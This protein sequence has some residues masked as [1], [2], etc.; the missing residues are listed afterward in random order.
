LQFHS[1]FPFEEVEHQVS[2]PFRIVSVRPLFRPDTRCGMTLLN[3]LNVAG[4]RKET[5][6]FKCVAFSSIPGRL[7]RKAPPLLGFWTVDVP[8]KGRLRCG[9]PANLG[10]PAT[11]WQGKTVV[12]WGDS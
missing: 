3:T 4:V 10:V 6:I 2:K 7:C 8:S 1:M 11:I 9:I 12:R 5:G